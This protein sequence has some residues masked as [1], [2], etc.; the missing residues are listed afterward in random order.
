M[1]NFDFNAGRL[2]RHLVPIIVWLL[3]LLSLGVIFYKKNQRL[4]FRGIVHNFR[5]EVAP[6]DL[7]VIKALTVSIYQPVLKDDILCVLDDEIL[8]SELN[9]V[10]AKLKLIK[11][12]IDMKQKSEGRRFKSDI[13]KARL[14]ILQ[15]K[16][17][18]EPEKISLMDK[19]VEFLRLQKLA[20]KNAVTEEEL[21]KCEFTVKTLKKKIVTKQKLLQQ[22]E[23]DLATKIERSKLFTS[24]QES[25]IG[26][27][28]IQSALSVEELKLKDLRLRLSKLVLRAPA[29]GVITSIWARE[30]DVVR[31]GEHIIGIV[32]PKPTTVMAYISPQQT[33][34]IKSGDVL[35]LQR[36]LSADGDVK[37]IVKY[38]GPAV[39]TLPKELWLHPDY[40][41]YGVPI[42]L[43]L[44]KENEL[45]PGEVVKIL[46]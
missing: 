27:G 22:S 39:D 3:V 36:T 17:A 38:L 2:K 24:E 14:A 1:G 43:I 30:G 6:L 16:V 10:N 19:E 35:D 13:E 9:L 26:D 46:K 45:I 21:V 29:T 8:T 11:S 32:Q 18:L 44:P 7:G 33:K 28:Y 12:K 41:Q 37:V 5:T 31:P 23:L 25:S 42:T 4:E 15:I 34:I 20:L 40:P